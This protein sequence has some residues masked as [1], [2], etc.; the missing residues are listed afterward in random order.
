[1]QLA[2]KYG[3]S[4]AVARRKAGLP[5][6]VHRTSSSD[7]TSLDKGGVQSITVAPSEAKCIE[8]VEVLDAAELFSEEPDLCRITR[9]EQRLMQIDTQ[10]IFTADVYPRHKHLVV[11]MSMIY[12]IT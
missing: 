8:D 1:M 12:F 7:N 5:P 2:D 10:P 6:I 11:K 4:A 9:L 3:L